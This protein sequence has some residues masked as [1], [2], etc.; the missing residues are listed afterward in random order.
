MYPR[1]VY[2][3]VGAVYL[4]L[5]CVSLERWI[6]LATRNRASEV[7]LRS[8][9]VPNYH[10]VNNDRD[11]FYWNKGRGSL[12]PFG[13][14]FI[15][16]AGNWTTLCMMD[17]DNDGVTNGQELGDPCCQWKTSP[18]IARFSLAKHREY[19][20]WCLT[21]PGDNKSS[22]TPPDFNWAS[23]KTCEDYNEDA[24]SER[25]V[26]FYYLQVRKPVK[27][28]PPHPKQLIGLV[29]TAM[30]FLHWSWNHG[31][32]FDMLPIF[33]LQKKQQIT[34]CIITHFVSFIF[35]DLTSGV[36]HLCLDYAPPWIPIMGPVANGFQVHHRDPALL[37]RKRLWNQ[38]N[39]VFIFMPVAVIFLLGSSPTRIM[40]LF[41]SV[42]IC[43]A[44]LFLCAHPWAHMHRDM[45]PYPVQVA[46]AWGVLLDQDRHK[47]HHE[48]LES[49]FTILSGKADIFI[50]T[51]SQI[52]P[53][54]RYDLW[55][56]FLVT[57][58]LIPVFLDIKCRPF[59][60]SLAR[61]SSPRAEKIEL[62]V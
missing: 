38:V 54:Q 61:S 28:D 41:W 44:L 15:A 39:D 62:S 51:L 52:V 43:Y 4:G 46:Q 29:S 19:R 23:P 40:R 17:S 3:S 37:A 30:L 47:K 48:D 6:R 22:W 49:Q 53:P 9:A 60:E 27:C 20:R 5:I 24:Y 13:E 21:N 50:D 56:F 14:D 8:H 36:A 1:L 10:H 12:N 58:I 11:I 16:A 32:M 34:M 31:L 7:L 59:M 2:G 18:P 26:Q 35:M 57:W 25:Y 55:M 42:S 45:V 33:G